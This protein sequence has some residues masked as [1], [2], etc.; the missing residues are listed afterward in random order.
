MLYFNHEGN[1][2][3]SE[4]MQLLKGGIDLFPYDINFGELPNIDKHEI[5][6]LKRAHRYCSIK[7]KTIIMIVWLYMMNFSNLRAFLKKG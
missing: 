2:T 6:K 1:D 5:T 3:N 7:M 4:Q